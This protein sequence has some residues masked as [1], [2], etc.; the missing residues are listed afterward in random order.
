MISFRGALQK[1]AK[2]EDHEEINFRHNDFWQDLTKD[3]NLIS[4]ELKARRAT[5]S[6]NND[7]QT[8]PEFAA[9]TKA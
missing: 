3:L 9:N 2:G 5:G 4:A 6:A 1:L 8:Q 7:E